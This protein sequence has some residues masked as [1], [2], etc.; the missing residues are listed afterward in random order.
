MSG[1]LFDLNVLLDI[2]TADV[3]W[4]GWSEAQFRAAATQEPILINP[5]VYA[6]LAPAFATQADL[7][8]WLDPAIFQ[9]LPRP[10]FR[11][12]PARRRH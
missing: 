11:E 4:L 5:I 1:I 7:D 2:A 6:K 12:I 8:E 3:T 10:S 9:R